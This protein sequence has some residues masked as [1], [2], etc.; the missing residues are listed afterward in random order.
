MFHCFSKMNKEEIFSIW[1]PE[2]SPWSVWAKPVLFAQIH[3]TLPPTAPSDGPESA[4]DITMLPSFDAKVA[5]VLDLPGAEGVRVGVALAARGYRPVPL[6]NAL[7]LPTVALILDPGTAPP[8]SAVDVSPI[9][10]ALTGETQH[11]AQKNLQPDAPPAFLLD[12]NRHGGAFNLLPGQFDNRSVCFT[13]DFPSANFL[14]AH[15]IERVLLVQRDRLEPLSDLAHALRRW[16]DGGLVLQRMRID[17]AST[18]EVF[19]VSK[20][21]W[22]GMMF[23]RAL[24]AMG[25]RRATGG[26]FGSWVPG[27]FVGWRLNECVR[28]TR[29]TT[30]V[31]ASR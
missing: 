22:F 15:G 8:V 18:P 24:I 1:A 27:S 16:Q 30:P 31:T 26:G 20:P 2:D 9:L 14:R 3:P 29:T 13:T 12:A 6:Y 25:I 19:E 4:L 17:P 21:S 11:L 23:Q 28:F 10:N 7:P 5:I